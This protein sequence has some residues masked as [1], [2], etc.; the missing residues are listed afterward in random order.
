MERPYNAVTRSACVGGA[1]VGTGQRM[2]RFIGMA[3]KHP[4]QSYCN[5]IPSVIYIAR[6]SGATLPT[7]MYISTHSLPTE[8]HTHT[9]CTEK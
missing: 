3:T 2:M 9:G 4:T 1:P 7:H 8:Y 5:T 6:L